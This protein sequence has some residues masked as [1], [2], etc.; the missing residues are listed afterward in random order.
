[1]LSG[2]LILHIYIWPIWVLHLCCTCMLYHAK[3]A[4]AQFMAAD[5]RVSSVLHCG[6]Q[7]VTYLWTHSS[8][9]LK[10]KNR[11]TA[12]L[13]N[14]TWQHT[15]G[16][17]RYNRK[18]C[19]CVYITKKKSWVIKG[20]V[21]PKICILSFPCHH[22]ILSAEHKRRFIV[23]FYLVDTMKVNWDSFENIFFLKKKKNA[24]MFRITWGWGNDGHTHLT[25]T[26]ICHTHTNPSSI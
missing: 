6:K 24:C 19:V 13:N 11:P 21:H 5:A 12:H 8:I 18:V 16:R 2:W 14:T 9:V 10:T 15:E 23:I 25:N 4:L 1:M 7:C 20:K 17:E 26:H 3:T 22:V